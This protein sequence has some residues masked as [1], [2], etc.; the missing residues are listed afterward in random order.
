WP[1]SRSSSSWTSRGSA[2]CSSMPAPTSST[3][4]SPSSRFPYQLFSSPQERPR[5][6]ASPASTAAST[7]SA[8]PNSYI[9][10]ALH[11]TNLHL[12]LFIRVQ[13]RRCWEVAM[14]RLVHVYNQTPRKEM[15]SNWKERFVISDD[16][17]IKQASTSNVMS[18][19][20]KLFY[21]RKDRKVMYAECKHEFLDLLLSFL[22]YPM[23]CILKN[24]AGTSH[25]CGSFN[26]LYRS[27]A[28][29]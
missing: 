16:L 28:G 15:F 22:I 6:A 9:P 24:L 3:S 12:H 13:R 18:F 21:D 11:A 25:L 19:L 17:V 5:R 26:N 14:A 10:V 4:S 23:G 20:I 7:A 8:T 1:P 2:S 27:A 29:L